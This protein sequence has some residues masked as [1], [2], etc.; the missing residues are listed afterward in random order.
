MLA[1]LV[2]LILLY[3]TVEWFFQKKV[4]LTGFVC[5]FYLYLMYFVFVQAKMCNICVTYLWNFGFLQRNISN[6]HSFHLLVSNDSYQLC[7]KFNFYFLLCLVK[8]SP[9]PYRFLSVMGLAGMELSFFIATHRVLCF[10][11]VTKQS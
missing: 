8:F 9:L 1:L 11:F 10:R 2:M 3:F 7:F 5:I 4:F 6:F